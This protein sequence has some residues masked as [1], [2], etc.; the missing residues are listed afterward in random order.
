MSHLF[1]L[2]GIVGGIGKPCGIVLSIGERGDA[3]LDI[4]QRIEPEGLAG[5]RIAMGILG[6]DLA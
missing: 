1:Q 3:E 5:D 4:V 2:A 6:Q